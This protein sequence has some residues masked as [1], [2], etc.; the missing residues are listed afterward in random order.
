VFWRAARQPLTLLALP[1]L[2][3]LEL[4]WGNA[5][6]LPLAP[7]DV[8]EA[9]HP[10]AAAIRA[11]A[12]RRVIPLAGGHAQRTVTGGDVRWAEVMRASLRPD[13]SGLERI[14]SLAFNLP[15]TQRRTWRALGP[16]ASLRGE[17]GP[18]F[19][20][21]WAITDLGGT[22]PAGA[23]RVLDDLRLELRLHR[24]PCR[25]R[26][27]LSAAQPVDE[28]RGVGLLRRGLP[29]GQSIWEAPSAAPA[30]EGTATLVIDE[31]ERQVIDAQASGPTA[32]VVSDELVPG[33]TAT[34]DGEPAPLYFTNVA[35]RG[36]SLP[37]G[38]HR[39]ELRYRTPGLTAG[40]WLSSAG[41]LLAL[42]GLRWRRPA[43]PQGA[44]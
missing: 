26:V 34:L 6:H 13:A 10:F 11:S 18:L 25:A 14:G 21:C 30:A 41:A 31:P 27:Y 39:V 3:L 17:T 23:V 36:V 24:L 35:V 4:A 22:P 38:R 2:L 16:N 5:A 7:R 40:L 19:G 42:L 20:G 33:W 1:P 8:L 29:P 44:A 43:P 32:L 37:A 12:E 28:Q 9:E 15:A